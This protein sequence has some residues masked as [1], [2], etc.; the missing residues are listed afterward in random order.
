ML[1]IYWLIHKCYFLY[2]FFCLIL[3][4]FASQSLLFF[5][6]LRSW[7]KLVTCV[8][9]DLMVLLCIHLDRL[10]FW[11]KTALQCM[12]RVSLVLCLL[13]LFRFFHFYLNFNSICLSSVFDSFLRVPLKT[14]AYKKKYK[15]KTNT[16]TDTSIS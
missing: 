8:H 11:V 6:P 2:V 16:I 3:V 12:W 13:I 15:T 4:C 1:W 10:I 5:I 7:S 9:I 14:H